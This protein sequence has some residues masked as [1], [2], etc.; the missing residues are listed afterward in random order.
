MNYCAWDPEKEHACTIGT[1]AH[2]LPSEILRGSPKQP[3]PQQWRRHIHRVSV[4]SGIAAHIGKGMGLSFLDF[5]DDGR[6]DVFVTNDT[7]PNFLFRNLGDGKF[8][9]VALQSGVAFNNDGRAVSSMGADARD[10]DNDGREDLF[11]TANESETFPSSGISARD[12]SPTSPMRAASAAKPDPR[13]VGARAIRGGTCD[14]FSVLLDA[15]IARMASAESRQSRDPHEQSR[16]VERRLLVGM[17]DSSSCGGSHS[18]C[19][20]CDGAPRPWR[21]RAGDRQSGPVQS[22]STSTQL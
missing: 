16:R 17:A 12:F 19:S 18:R 2:L 8:E 3:L 14:T 5:D 9:N 22:V 7:T 6:L 21:P 13:R 10:I 15:T 4:R 1:C 20:W 11:I